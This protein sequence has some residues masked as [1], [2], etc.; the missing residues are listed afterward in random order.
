MN[1]VVEDLSSIS[2]A[3]DL[4]SGIVNPD[5]L[6]YG[7]S[8][9]NNS[10]KEKR[11]SADG[12]PNTELINAGI[13]LAGEIVGLAAGARKTELEKAIHSSCGRRP[14]VGKVRKESYRTCANQV[15]KTLTYTPESLDSEDKSS[16][17]NKNTNN[18]SQNTSSNGI[19]TG[20][21]VGIVL[22]VLAV[23][24]LVVVLVVKA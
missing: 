9:R 11:S 1:L 12:E 2:H 23:G 18:N 16:D 13:N 8:G 21:I 3:D 20:A 24:T 19:S 15:L 22:G 14:L 10:R 5:D 4:M 7:A 6:T 17:S